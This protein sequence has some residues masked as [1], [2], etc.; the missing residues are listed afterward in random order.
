MKNKT[1]LFILSLLIIVSSTLLGQNNNSVFLDS[2]FG[3]KEYLL[4]VKDSMAT[5][6]KCSQRI[7]ENNV[8]KLPKIIFEEIHLQTGS[9]I[10]IANPHSKFNATGIVLYR[11]KPD[12]RLLFCVHDENSW[13]LAYE[14]GGLGYHHHFIYVRMEEDGM[15]EMT[16]LIGISYSI[17]ELLAALSDKNNLML[18]FS[19]EREIHCYDAF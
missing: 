9:K 11:N 2:L 16:S 15:I 12:R 14:H 8:R 5:L 4:P 1:R 18:T 3:P 10:R 6:L 7:S 13:I 17:D 19:K